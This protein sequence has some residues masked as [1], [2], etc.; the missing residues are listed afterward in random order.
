MIGGRSG[1]ISKEPAHLYRTVGLNEIAFY[2]P[3]NFTYPAGAYIAEVEIDR[4]T[5]TV[6][7]D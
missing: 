5:S 3:I 1:V 4:E 6:E 2:D 7:L